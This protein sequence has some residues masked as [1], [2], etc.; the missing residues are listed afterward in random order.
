[1]PLTELGPR[2]LPALVVA[3]G[4]AAVLIP[5]MSRPAQRVGLV[6]H[7]DHRKRH[8][9]STPLTGGL[10]IVAGFI[11][12]LLLTDL[13]WLPYWTL[14]VGVLVLMATGLLDDLYDVP[15]SVRLLIQIGVAA[16]M[17]L[18]G[19]LKVQYLGLPLGPGMG[20]VGLGPL[21]APFTIACVVFMINAINMADG[22]DGLAGG[23]STLILLL[24][25]L[26]A[27]LGELEPGLV[28]LPLV[29]AL[30]TLGFLV[31][32]LR[33]PGGRHARAFLGDTGSMM[34]G[35][36]LAWIAVAIGTRPDLPVYPITVAWLLIVPGMDTLALFF[37][38]IRLGRS[39]FSPDRTHMH[40]IL[41]RC[42]YS[43][44]TTVLTI[45]LLVLAAG[46]IGVLGW[47][48]SWPQWLMFALAAAVMLGYQ[49]LL[50]R[51]RRLVRWHGRRRGKG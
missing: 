50:A 29:L 39:P 11:A 35:Y 34:L 30:A 47:L 2:L 4:V 18:G 48:Q 7:P 45:Y 51:A 17:V 26:V 37:R 23:M 16:L 44:A 14:I 40:H 3:F 25:A 24:L 15:A 20:P 19:G 10:A 46:I 1:M 8:V 36:A 49:W 12:G 13:A 9:Q 31:H 41:R 6:D 5:A 28:I 27:F 33:L 21:A 22:L 32:N 38:R 42:G 43:V